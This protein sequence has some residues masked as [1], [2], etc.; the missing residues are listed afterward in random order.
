MREVL[1]RLEE[2][3]F[4]SAPEIRVVSVQDDGEVVRV[5]VRSR[6][7]KA[8]CPGCG[9][10]S[11]RVH[12]SY[13]RFP[14]DLPVAGRRVVLRLRV[15]RF[16]C[17]DASCERQ[18]FV[19]QVTGLTRR[20]TQRT[21]RMRSALAEVGLALAGRAG[22][23]LAD[24]FGARAS[25]NTVL[26]LVDA[27]PEPQQPPPRVVGVDEYAMRKGRVYGTVLV[28]VETRRPIDLLPDREAATVAAWLAE[29]PGIEV[30]CRDR[31]PFFAEGA[32]TG[33]PTAVQ[34][35]DRFHLWRNLGEAAERCISR[36]RS[37]LRATTAKA[38]P[39]KSEA[40]TPA[41]GGSPWP[42]GHRFADRTRAKHATVHALLAAGHSRR[43][44]QRQ[45]GMT[46]RTVQRLA[47]A[48][49]PEDLFQGQW[50]NRKTKLDDFKP[51]LNDR[52]AEGC[53]N[54]W[55]L[56]EEIKTHGYHGGYGA[57]RA[58]LQPFR[59]TPTS[60][61]ARPPSP[62]TVAGWILTHPD[63]LPESERLKLKSVLAHCP[64]LDALTG[65]VRT[66]GRV[67]TEL[68]GDRLPQWI[69]AVR[70]DDLP[71]LH[72]FANGLE[73]DLAAVTAGLTLPW[74]SGVVEGHVNRIKMIKRQ[75]YGR[76]GFGLLRKRVLLAS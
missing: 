11:E 35:A 74:S 7:T 37:C 9:S 57:V 63:T 12:G 70:A 32:S 55:T 13:L 50:Q 61:A 60:P 58:Y 69:K 72:T 38:A 67:I 34:V 27:L 66:F 5:G 52:W 42:T 59:T 24:A 4:L 29:R 22:A 68:Q 51:Y 16:T 65:H 31:A 18:T 75:M 6:P 23:R 15:R 3:L 46:Y 20:H 10:W 54:A 73:R 30:V 8:C 33:A 19:E 49:R 48:A 76:A 14:A 21:E 17:D 41:D 36:H 25:R 2:L 53:T 40:Q 64:E 28:D 45:L 47:D 26:R 62:R 43:S 39:Q 71:S 44:I 1:L 56:W